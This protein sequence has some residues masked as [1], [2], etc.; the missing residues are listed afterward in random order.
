MKFFN[1]Y[2]YVS[3][4]DGSDCGPACLAA[5][6]KQYGSYIKISKIREEAGTD[7]FGTSLFGLIK[8][9]EKM[10]FQCKAIEMHNKN[11]ISKDFPKPAIVHI[12]T[13]QNLQHYIVLHEVNKKNIIVADPSQGIVEYK[14]DDFFKL[15]DGVVLLL[16]PNKNF[17]QEKKDRQIFREYKEL[18]KTQ[19][20]FFGIIFII[21]ILLNLFGLTGTIYYK[22][23]LDNVANNDNTNN[24][25]IVSLGVILLIVL[26]SIIEFFRSILIA[27]VSLNL[28]KL[29]VMKFYNH[30]INLPMEFF[31]TRRVGD[32][33]SRFND[34]TKIRDM[35]SSVTISVMFD[36]LMVILG[37]IIL[38][39]YNRTLFLLCIFPVSLYL[40]LMFIFKKPL[41]KTNRQLM[42]SDSE[43]Y[44]YLVESLSGIEMV[45]SV[46]GENLSNKRMDEKFSNV[47]KKNLNYSYVENLHI[48]LKSS[49]E[50]LFTV[51]VLWIG[52][53][54]VLD[55]LYSVG[56]LISY[57]ALLVYFIGPMERIIG[58][59]SQ[60]QSAAVASERLSQIMEISKEEKV[61]NA[62]EYYKNNS[63]LGDIIFQKVDFRYGTK[64]KILKNISLHIKKGQKVAFV[65][66]SGSGKTTIAKLLMNFYE[67]ESGQIEINFHKIQ[68]IDKGLL[69]DKIGYVSQN[70][71]FFSGTIKENL[72]FV[73]PDLTYEKMTEVCKLV[74]MHDYIESLHYKYDTSLEENAAN[75]SAGQRQRLS[76]AKALIRNPEILIMDEATSNLDVINEMKIEKA[77]DNYEVKNTRIIIAHRL[78]TIVNCDRIFVFKNG[79]LIE[80]GTHEELINKGGHYYELSNIQSLNRR[81]NNIKLIT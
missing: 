6:A 22:F 24:L 2:C 47:L 45:K 63:L 75:L 60:I 48:S 32:I 69:R 73:K 39:C 4:H 8:A 54:Q 79:E 70:Y 64:E 67:I 51:L 49:I 61:E 43:F 30:V 80:E 41:E 21:S 25:Q 81:K 72:L 26:K 3:Q 20:K 34:A 62:N 74:Q 44:S 46:N 12:R 37:T 17:K 52:V 78:S 77:L 40:L 57:N 1:K 33:I 53:L 36:L 76:I 66:E 15:W 59:Q 42:I 9:A 10:N 16:V 65:G 55:G 38:C 13:Q 50:G 35:L 68:D 7:R 18:I 31:R 5:V 58:L 11:N 56:T 71:F 23:I 14:I 29:I 27:K 19:K 28:D